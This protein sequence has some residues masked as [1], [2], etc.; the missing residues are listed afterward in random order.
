AFHRGAQVDHDPMFRLTTP[1]LARPSGPRAS[2]LGLSRRRFIQSC[3]VL[4]LSGLATAAYGVGIERESLLV[5]RYRLAPPGWPA[6]RRLSINVI[7]DLHAGGPNMTEGQIEH[8]VEVANLDPP[9]L[10]LLLGDYFATHR[11]VTERVPHP[12]WAASLARLKSRLGT[13]AILG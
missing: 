7:A 1:S 6:G 5:A 12:V 13:W 3:G 2:R 4:G 11:Y 10:V 8:I 9:D